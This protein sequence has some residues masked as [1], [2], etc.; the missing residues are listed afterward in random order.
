[1][2]GGLPRSFAYPLVAMAM[3]ALVRGKPW[4]LCGLTVLGAA[5]YYP[6]AI[7]LG[8]TTAGYLLLMPQSWRGDER[9][10]SIRRRLGA[11]CA[12]AV[13]AAILMVP[14]LVAGRTFGPMLQRAD[15]AAYP[16]AAPGGRYDDIDLPVS[17]K[18]I[19]TAAL[20]AT[21]PLLSEGPAWNAA[22]RKRVLRAVEDPAMV[23]F[24]CLLLLVGYA[25]LVAAD[26]GA[27]RLLVLMV[28]AFAL[29][30]LSLALWPAVLLPSRYLAY[31]LPLVTGVAVPVAI[32]SCLQRWRVVRARPIAA[33]ALVVAAVAGLV[34]CLGGT[35]PGH[36]GLVV[37]IPDE[38]RPL[39]G[40]LAR[41]PP[42]AMI[43]G[44]PDSV[45]DSVPYLTGR[46]ILVGYETHQ[47]FHK[48]Y[49]E[50]MRRRMQ[51]LVDAYFSSDV[52]PLLRLHR[53]FGVTHLLVNRGHYGPGAP[54]YFKPFDAMIAE[55]VRNAPAQPAAL[56]QDAAATVFADGPFLLL[57]L[58]RIGAQPA[59]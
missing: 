44:W 2:V 53:E 22:L 1:M 24:G 31:T 18:L 21:R 23:V 11:L 48:G 10:W 26:R 36:A 56:R 27:R 4:R 58:R 32:A 25:S 13:T 51:A 37:N 43:A 29:Y 28:S 49:V 17:G 8:F 57:D 52:G 15:L 59:G 12:T 20:Y 19:E 33:G 45:V 41:L 50:E 7:L 9:G 38:R 34:L 47:A 14:A 55:A 3:L 35:G 16:E 5:F 54:S 40:F 6:V 39:Y 30:G 42:D 46:R